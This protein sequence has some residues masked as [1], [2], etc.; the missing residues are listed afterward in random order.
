MVRR[1]AL[2][3]PDVGP[4]PGDRGDAEEATG[5]GAEGIEPLMEVR[6]HERREYATTCRSIRLGPGLEQGTLVRRGGVVTA[7]GDAGMRREARIMELR[8]RSGEYM[9]NRVGCAL[10]GS[11]LRRV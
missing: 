5:A 1:R 7:D 10:L 2:V 3:D 6:V 11:H 4:F 9:R 8:G